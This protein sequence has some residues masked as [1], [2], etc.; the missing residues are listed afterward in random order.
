MGTPKCV[1]K[2]DGSPGPLTSH[3]RPASAVRA[4]LRG[5]C[6]LPRGSRCQL[7]VVSVGIELSCGRR[8]RCPGNNFRTDDITIPQNANKIK[9]SPRDL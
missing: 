9:M 6:L 3:L 8:C 7:W 1:A 5:T 2:L 4:V